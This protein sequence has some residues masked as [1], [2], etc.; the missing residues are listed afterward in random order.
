MAHNVVLVGGSFCQT[1]IPRLDIRQR[2]TFHIDVE[3]A[4]GDTTK[5]DVAHGEGITADIGMAREMVIKNGECR[6]CFVAQI[7]NLGEIA[8]I[9][10]R[11]DCREKQIDHRHKR[12]G[13]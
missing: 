11:A 8:G 6:V 5:G 9:W 7:V 4:I 13:G 12:L 2:G 10:L 3:V 1:F